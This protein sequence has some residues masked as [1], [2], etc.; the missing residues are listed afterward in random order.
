MTPR[1]HRALTDLQNVVS[2]YAALALLE[3][4]ADDA[5]ALHRV[6]FFLATYPDS[7]RYVPDA[8]L[9]NVLL[10]LLPRLSAGHAL[11]SDIEFATSTLLGR[12]ERQM[13]DA[14]AHAAA[15]ES[16]G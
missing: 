8:T 15:T 10:T 4:R 16:E 6:A 14:A 3:G 12:L 2:I 7:L 13:A 5:A 1:L 11:V 9:P